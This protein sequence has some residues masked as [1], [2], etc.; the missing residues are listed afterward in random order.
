ML[1]EPNITVFISP[2]LKIYQQNIFYI[3]YCIEWFLLN[4]WSSTLSLHTKK[5]DTYYQH[6]N[7]THLG[8]LRESVISHH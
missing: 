7:S 8:M 6:L 2:T 4:L 5:I 1:Y 3:S